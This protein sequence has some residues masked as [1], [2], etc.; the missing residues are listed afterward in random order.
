MIDVE[1]DVVLDDPAR[2]RYRYWL[3]RRLGSEGRPLA[4]IGWNPSLADSARDDPSVRRMLGFARAAGASDLVVVNLLA[5]I[6]ARPEALALL[7][8]PAGPLADD[9]LLA[10]ASF[11]TTL[12]AAWGIPKGHA[13]THAVAAIRARRIEA[14]GRPLH[15]LRLTRDGH[16]C[17]PLYL[18]A[19]LGLSAWSPDVTPARRCAAG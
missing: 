6:A 11:C 10:A 17:H 9:A 1:A 13:A 3:R 12:V 8:D 2:P 19:T 16:P 15:V 5:G 18:P 4:F 14:L 7:E